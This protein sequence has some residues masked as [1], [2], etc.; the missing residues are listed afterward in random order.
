[1]Y[2]QPSCL[3]TAKH[4]GSF[5]LEWAKHGANFPGSSRHRV[6]LLSPYPVFKTQMNL[7]MKNMQLSS[8]PFINYFIQQI[9]LLSFHCRGRE[10]VSEE[11]K[12]TV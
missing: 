12:H 4:L 8:V 6:Q 10:K 7:K 3:C 11:N 1:M 9:L 2:K 5:I